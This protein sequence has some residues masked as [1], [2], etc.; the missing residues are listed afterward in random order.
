MLI[1]LILVPSPVLVCV[2]DLKP[3]NTSTQCSVTACMTECLE[4]KSVA[5]YTLLAKSVFKSRSKSFYRKHAAHRL[6]MHKHV[7][8]M[9]R[10]CRHQPRVA[11]LQSEPQPMAEN[12]PLPKLLEAFETS[13]CSLLTS[14]EYGH[15]NMFQHIRR[16][17]IPIR[18]LSRI[19]DEFGC[20]D[21]KETN[22]QHQPTSTSIIPMIG[23]R[24]FLRPPQRTHIEV[25]LLFDLCLLSHSPKSLADR[26]RQVMKGIWCLWYS[27]NR[28]MLRCDTF[29]AGAS[30]DLPNSWKFKA[31]AD[32][33]LL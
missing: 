20:S 23:Y 11:W 2:S 5:Y 22:I 1:V 21:A 3:S 12:K 15:S 26:R 18:S 4:G 13:L 28:S 14:A 17:P 30:N 32:V 25:V 29:S 7:L 31:K 24:W 6:F 8:W 27:I 9:F 19:R 10:W 33:T 16:L